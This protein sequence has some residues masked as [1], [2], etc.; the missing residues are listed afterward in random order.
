[1]ELAVGDGPSGPGTILTTNG[2]PA[3]PGGTTRQIDAV[4]VQ[5]RVCFLH[6]LLRPTYVL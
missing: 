1:M 3:K 6:L 5:W 2:C 4:F